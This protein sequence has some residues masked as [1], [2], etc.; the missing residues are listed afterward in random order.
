MVVGGGGRAGSRTKALTKWQKRKKALKVKQGFAPSWTRSEASNTY[1]NDALTRD[2]TWNEER[3]CEY[4]APNA[5][6]FRR[7][8]SF[9]VALAYDTP[10]RFR[11]SRF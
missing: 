1:S 7:R 3:H 4:A 2:M 5:E 11:R 9:V 6:R 8:D 10:T